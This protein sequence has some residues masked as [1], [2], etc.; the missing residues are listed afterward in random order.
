MAEIQVP[1]SRVRLAF[2]AQVDERGGVGNEWNSLKVDELVVFPSSGNARCVLRN[3]VIIVAKYANY[4]PFDMSSQLKWEGID[5]A[6]CQV[7]GQQFV[8][9]QGLGKHMTVKHPGQTKGK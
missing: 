1:A 7:C 2:P 3:G 5:A 6:K 9:T 8:N 4:V